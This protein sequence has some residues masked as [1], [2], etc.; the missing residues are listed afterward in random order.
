MIEQ[1]QQGARNAVI[2]MQTGREQTEQSVEQIV[3]AGGRLDSI[4]SAVDRIT[5]M[6]LQIATAAEEQ[7]K[8]AEEMAHNIADISRV[9]DETA[10]GAQHTSSASQQLAQLSLQ[11]RGLISHFKV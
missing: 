8:V 4:T 10:L 1:L 11:L 9:S 6:N 7:S 3:Q 5:E 2:A